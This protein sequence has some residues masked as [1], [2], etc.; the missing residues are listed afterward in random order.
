MLKNYFKIVLRDLSKDK[1]YTIISIIGLSAAVSIAIIILTI[2]FSFLTRDRF[3]E[4]GDRIYQAVCRIDFLK[5]GTQYST[6]MPTML[7]ESLTQE[8]PEIKQSATI[9]DNGSLAFIVGNKRF[10][11]KGYYSEGSLFKIFSFPIVKKSSEIIFPNDNSIAI[12]RSLAVKYFG[13]VSGALGKEIIIRQTYERNKVF[14]SG[15]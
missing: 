7:G 14:V 4:K 10:E 12:S 5:A 3:H 13:S 9:K 6:T 2:N 1:I 11:Q 8:Y 15:V